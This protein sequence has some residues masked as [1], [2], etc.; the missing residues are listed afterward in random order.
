MAKCVKLLLTFFPGVLLLFFLCWQLSATAPDD[1]EQDYIAHGGGAIEGYTVTNSLEAVMNAIAGGI[2]FIELD[3]RLTSDGKLVATHDWNTFRLQTG[4]DSICTIPPS[5]DTFRKSRIWGK[6]TPMTYE[7]IDSVFNANTDLYLV[8]DKITDMDVIER[9]LPSLGDRII[10]ECFSKAQYDD[11]IRR[12]FRPM[13]SFHNLCP[14]GVNVVADR[15]FRYRYQHLVPTGFAMCSN[16]GVSVADA[17][18][19]FRSDSRIRFVYVDF[20]D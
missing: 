7:L 1:K 8:T 6:Y 16:G 11:C 15:S 2:R 14:G 17:D 13:R 5:Y 9:Y 10:V 12:G 3:L 18:S 19:I 4:C 20:F